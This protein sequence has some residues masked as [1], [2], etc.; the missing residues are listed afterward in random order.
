MNPEKNAD[1]VTFV[2]NGDWQEQSKN[3]KAKFMHLTD[4]DLKLEPGREN[5]M[6]KRLESRLFKNRDEVIDIIKINETETP[7]SH[8]E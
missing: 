2:I 6:L 3:L 7:V 8:T 4:G 1:P 5:D